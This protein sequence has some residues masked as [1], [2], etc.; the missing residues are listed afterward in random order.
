[1]QRLETSWARRYNDRRGRY[2]HVFQGRFASCV[3]STDLHLR[4]ALRYIALNPVRAGICHR[5]ADFPWSAHRALV[6]FDPPRFLSVD[7]ALEPFGR[8]GDA[9]KTYEAFVADRT[10]AEHFALA[11]E[12][13]SADPS[14]AQF[15]LR[16]LARHADP[17]TVIVTGH[18]ELGLPFA[19]IARVLGCSRWTVARRFAK[20]RPDRAPLGD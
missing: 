11:V 7:A 9:M 19:A 14:P 4:E 15:A 8:G 6:G 16:E 18:E 5:P 3:V 20:L 12:G 1:M 10:A 17:E 2:G 13:E